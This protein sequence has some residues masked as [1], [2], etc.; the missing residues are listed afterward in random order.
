MDFKVMQRFSTGHK[1]FIS[2]CG[3]NAPTGETLQGSY[4]SA[5]IQMNARR[6]VGRRAEGALSETVSRY[7]PRAGLFASHRRKEL[8]E[9][10][11]ADFQSQ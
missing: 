9:P 4:L 2:L 8:G 3:H 11:I 5:N 6:N 7:G 1:E 10:T